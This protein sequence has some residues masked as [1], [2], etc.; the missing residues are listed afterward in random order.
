MK[1]PETPLRSDIVF[2]V[3]NAKLLPPHTVVKPR[4]DSIPKKLQCT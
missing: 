2:S 4:D 1:T 3:T